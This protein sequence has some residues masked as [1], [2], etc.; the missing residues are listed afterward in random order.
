MGSS[1]YLGNDHPEEREAECEEDNAG[2]DAR[3]CV[4]LPGAREVEDESDCR[5]CE[6]GVFPCCEGS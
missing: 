4:T 2:D 5:A 3:C 1:V 6:H